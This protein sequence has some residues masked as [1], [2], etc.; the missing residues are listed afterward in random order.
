MLFVP[1]SAGGGLVCLDFPGWVHVS[2]AFGV[3]LFRSVLSSTP[4]IPVYVRDFTGPV[5]QLSVKKLPGMESVA[6]LDQAESNKGDS[7]CRLLCSFLTSFSLLKFVLL[8]TL[9]PQSFWSTVSGMFGSNVEGK[10]KDDTVHVFSLASGHLYERFLKIMMLSVTKVC[11]LLF[12]GCN[13][14]ASYPHRISVCCCSAINRVPYCARLRGSSV[15]LIVL[16][17]PTQRSSSHIKFWLVE[18]FLSPQFKELVPKLADKCV[19]RCFRCP[20]MVCHIPVRPWMS[21]Y[22]FEVALVT[23]KWPNWLH[24]QKEKQRIIWGYKILFLDVLFPLNLTKVRISFFPRSVC[25]YLVH[26]NCV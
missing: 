3:C 16:W 5:T 11:H 10:A 2:S 23:Y 4:S 13:I 17:C 20:S 22:G 1:D 19:L 8:L 6:L 12:K 9:L 14:T 18:N 25:A 24:Q 7:V 26:C 15:V 21:R